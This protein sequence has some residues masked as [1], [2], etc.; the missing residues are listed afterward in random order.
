MS[1]LLNGNVRQVKAWGRRQ[2]PQGLSCR[3]VSE[4]RS[5]GVAQEF[6]QV[7]LHLVHRALDDLSGYVAERGRPYLAMYLHEAIIAALFSRWAELED[8]VRGLVALEVAQR[9]RNALAHGLIE[10]SGSTTDHVDLLKHIETLSPQ[11]RKAKEGR[12]KIPPELVTFISARVL[13]DLSEESIH[14]VYLSKLERLR[15]GLGLN[16]NELAQLL[17]VTPEAIRKW[18]R[19]GGISPGVRGAIDLHLALLDRLE[20]YIRPG[21]LPA[22]LRR[23]ARGLE[24]RRPIA[25]VLG[26]DEE[27][28]VQ[29]FE[30]LTTYASTA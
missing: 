5:P 1:V 25:L 26:G 9:A 11:S 19:G 17:S 27:T 23:P 24:G 20:T 15:S 7:G 4:G 18:V 30:N 21:L 14:D 2:H 22:V 29:Y 28:L 12:R 3:R 10:P 8:D 16:Q 6:A 13:Q